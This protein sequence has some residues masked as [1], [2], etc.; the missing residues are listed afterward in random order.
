[1][2][3]C[4]SPSMPRNIREWVP[5]NIFVQSEIRTSKVETASCATG[6]NAEGTNGL[7]VLS[8]LVEQID[9]L[10]HFARNV[11]AGEN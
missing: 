6:S 3:A 2:A 9:L 10:H 4:H 1:M 11:I 5:S 8:A 7:V